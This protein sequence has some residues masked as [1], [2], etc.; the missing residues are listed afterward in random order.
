[1][2]RIWKFPL[3]VEDEQELD[4]PSLACVLCVQVQ[5]EIPCLWALVDDKRPTVRRIVHILGTGHVATGAE[6]S[7]YVGT[8]Q[9]L[10]GSFVG[11]VFV[12]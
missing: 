8:F 9:L 3:K 11:H 1:M 10:S 6:S 2:M 5:N 7:H 12:D 4:M